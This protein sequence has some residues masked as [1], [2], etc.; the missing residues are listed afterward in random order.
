MSPNNTYIPSSPHT[1]VVGLQWGDEGKGKVVDLLASR[2]D[3]IVRYNGGANAGHT[4]VVGDQRYAVHLI[5][6]GI[7]SPDTQC[8]I[9]NGVVVDPAKLV[10][11]INTLRAR[12]IHIGTNLIVSNRAHVVMPY[13]KEHDAA[14]ERMLA[15]AVS[16]DGVDLSIGTTKRGIGPAYADK[17]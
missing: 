6:A 1:A 5:P 16:S 2:H 14:M 11:E 10:D 4:V 7:L 13:H 3:L 15:S 8:V 9:A 12:D 17:V